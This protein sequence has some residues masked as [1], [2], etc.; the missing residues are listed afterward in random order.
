M[1]ISSGTK[2]GCYEIV[3]QIGEGGMGV[4]YQAHDSK[5]GCD[6]AIKVLVVKISHS[7]FN[8]PRPTKT[9]DFG[10]GIRHTSSWQSR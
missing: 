3:A 2:F 9:D 6:V 5:L 4:V 10:N 7:L 1:S 8:S